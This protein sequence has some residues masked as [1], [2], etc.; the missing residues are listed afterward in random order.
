MRY[1][2]CISGLYKISKVRDSSVSIVIAYGLDDKSWI[3]GTVRNVS[4]R[5]NV[6]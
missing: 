4:L 3:L 5:H 6:Y 1:L 2:R